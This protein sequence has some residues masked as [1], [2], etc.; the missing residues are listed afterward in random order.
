MAE[1]R[2]FA[3]LNLGHPGLLTYFPSDDPGHKPGILHTTRLT[4]EVPHF[5]IVGSSAE[6]YPPSKSAFP[7]ASAKSWRERNIQQRWLSNSHPEALIGGADAFSDFLKEDMNRF[8]KTDDFQDD[9]PL[10]AVGEM[11]D[12]SIPSIPKGTPLLAVATG[13]SGEKLRLAKV[14]ESIWQ[15]DGHRDAS[16][17]LS[18]VDPMFR[19]EETIWCGDGLPISKIRF[20]TANRQTNSIRWLLVQTNTSV[21]ILQ[22]EYHRVLKPGSNAGPSSSLVQAPSYIASNPLI[23]LHHHQTGGNELSDVCFN[24]PSPGSPPRIDV[25][26]QCGFWSVW[27][28]MGA[29]HG[30]NKTLRLSLYKCGHITDGILVSLPHGSINP[31]RRHGMIRIGRTEYDENRNVSAKRE[32]NMKRTPR[33]SQLVLMWNSQQILLLDLDTESLLRKID[34]PGQSKRK[35]DLI[36]DIQESPVNEN[37]VFVLTTRQVVWLDVLPCHEDSET[38][39]SPRILLSCSLVGFDNEDAKMS[40]C[41]ASEHDSDGCMVFV[42]S[43]RIDQ[44]T[45]YWFSFAPDVQ[46]PQWHRHITSLSGGEEEVPLRKTQLI[47]AQPAKLEIVTATAKT[48]P[49]TEYAQKNI[50]FYQL[51]TLGEDLSVRYCVCTSSVET[52]AEVNLPTFRVG[53]TQ[54]EQRKRWKKKRTR[55]LKHMADTFVTPDGMT[56][57]HVELLLRQNRSKL[58]H[59]Q[60]SDESTSDKPRPIYINSSKLR[61]TVQS[62]VSSLQEA[63][64]HGECGLPTEM[65]D[66]VQKTVDFG[67]TRGSLPLTAWLDLFPH[68][69]RTFPSNQPGDGM[70]EEIERF[71]DNVEEPVVIR[72]LRRRFIDE[73]PG[74][75]LGFPYLLETYSKIW[76]SPVVNLVPPEMQHVQRICVADIARDIFLSSYGV[77]VQNAPG[78]GAN[79]SEVM[80][81]SQSDTPT[82]HSVRLTPSSPGIT[83][84]PPVGSMSLQEA[85]DAAF[86]HLQPL[87]PS[88]KQ[89]TLGSLGQSKILSYWPNQLGINTEHYVSSVAIAT[90]EKFSYAK[91]R[92]RKIEAKRKA[93][94]E[95]YKLPA[96][97]RQRFPAGDNMGEDD[98]AM[99]AQRQRPMQVMSSQQGGLDSS[100][101]FGFAGPSVTMSQPV[102]GAFGDRKKVKKGKRKSGFR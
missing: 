41:R 57:K 30:G 1:H 83:S 46:L 64:P 27:S 12:W 15:W 87:V 81:N 70:E 50:K 14:D 79:G 47:R 34:I 78:L 101:S 102:S 40:I 2:R 3:D 93:Q 60:S 68:I 77:M 69:E 96:F 65:I 91:Q 75:F 42:H 58:D 94:A 26:D 37:H 71:L 22:P 38:I 19:D 52:A 63:I 43:P 98:S 25:I 21:T 8:E 32:K 72:Q 5:N 97:R 73:L 51:T 92:L 59:E 29:G 95:K 100:Q 61:R 17:H 85:P 54:L 18:V 36:L 31:V 48:G 35:Q 24:P 11:T 84:S 23:T 88:F 55:L 89:G 99:E 67:L 90:E 4:S 45:V 66:V 49:G 16:L 53:W 82:Q 62:I 44:L 20:A 80:N 86:Q 28:I 10:L 13:E 9:G 76:L 7:E 6:L 74:S 39:L 33:P 56:D